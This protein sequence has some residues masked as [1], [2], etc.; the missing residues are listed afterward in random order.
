MKKLPSPVHLLPFAHQLSYV[1]VINQTQQEHYH[2]KNVGNMFAK[3]D[4]KK[5]MKLSLKDSDLMLQSSSIFD[6][7]FTLK[8]FVGISCLHVFS[9]FFNL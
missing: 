1:S 2:T 3:F 4:E 5:S 7:L 9:R 6:I 8:N